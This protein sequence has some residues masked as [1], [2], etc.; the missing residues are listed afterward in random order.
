VIVS[1]P[2][3]PQPVAARYGWA[4]NSDCDLVGG[5]GLPAPPFRTDRWPGITH[6]RH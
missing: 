5:T 3:V 1:S 4:D 2:A 6:G